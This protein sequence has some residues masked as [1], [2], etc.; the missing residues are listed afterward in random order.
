MGFAETGTVYLIVGFS[1]AIAM[2]RRERGQSWARAVATFVVHTALW[3][4]FA[5]LLFDGGQRP[6][7]LATPPTRVTAAEHRLLAAMESLDGIAEEVLGPEI[8]RIRGMTTDLEAAERRLEEMEDLLKTPEFDLKRVA[9]TLRDLRDRE[10]DEDDPRIQSV[11]ARERNI[12]RLTRLR[13]QAHAD[14]ERATFELEEMSAQIRVLRFADRPDTALIELV[15][16]VAATVEGVTE[17][18]LALA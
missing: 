7:P 11:L 3:P 5:P 12:V 10:L 14:L 8:A 1:C 6:Q 13:D 2:W 18:L 4:F 15:R 9:E 17:R 16:E